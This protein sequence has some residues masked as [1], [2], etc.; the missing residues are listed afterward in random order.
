MFKLPGLNY[1]YDALAGWVSADTMRAHHD[2]HHQ[3]YVDK[4]NAAT[5]QLPPEVFAKYFAN[6]ERNGE[7]SPDFLRPF[8]DDIASGKLDAEIPEKLRQILRNQGGGHFNHTLFWLFLTPKG[9]GEPG[10]IL[11]EKLREKFGSFQ[12]FAN[13]F[14]AA[15]TGIFGSGW[16]WLV[17]RNG[18]PEIMTSA[19]QDLPPAKILL[20]LDVWE[21]AYYL[22]YK[23]NR[24]DYVKAWWAHVDWARAAAKFAEN[25]FA[26][27]S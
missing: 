19:N 25:P 3:T 23:W 5:E 6:R 24:A 1:D 20:G 16:A 22:D 4:L 2:H 8:L 10:G 18:E 11:G 15:A 12:D 17:S 7:I 26:E 21:H 9:D 13:E 27:K 14:E